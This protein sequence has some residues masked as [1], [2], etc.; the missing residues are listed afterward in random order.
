MTLPN[1]APASEPASAE[2][3]DRPRPTFDSLPLSQ[4]LRETLAEIGYLEPTPVQLAVFEPATRGRDLVVQAQTGTGKTASF[5]LPIV[6]SIVR[7]SQAEVQV[8]VLCPTRELALQVAREIERLASRKTIAV[9]SVYG[10]APMQRQIDAIAGGAQVV[11][12]TPGRVLDH[13]RRG[14]LEAEHVRLLV[15]D[16]S[17]EML[18]MGFER[19]L[20]AILEFLPKGRQTLLFSAT[21]P[22]EIE[23]IAKNKLRSPEFLTLSSDRV[24]AMG[25]QHF[26]Y[27]VSSDKVGSLARIIEVENPESAVVFCNTKEETQTV[28]Q[29]LVRQGFDADWLNGDLPQSEREKVMTATR[30]GRL[31]FLVAT[32]VAARG[33]DI[34]HLTHVINHDFPVTAEA[35]VHRTG[36]TGRAGRTGTAI[37]LVTPHDFGALYYLRLTYKIRPV[38]RELPSEGEIRTRSEADLVAMLVE[39]FGADGAFTA[40]DRSIARR[41]LTHDDAEQVVAGMI[42]NY[43]GARPTA[44]EEASAERRASRRDREV[45]HAHVAEP[46]RAEAEGD[47]APGGASAP[48]TERASETRADDRGERPRDRG[49]ERRRDGRDDRRGGRRDDRPRDDRPRDDR[50]RE[51]GSRDGGHR[52]ARFEARGDG[53]GRPD[54][55]D[56]QRGGERGRADERPAASREPVR[57]D[58]G[59]V[60]A[61]SP[62]ARSEGG[63]RVLLDWHPPVEEGDD[64]PILTKDAPALSAPHEPSR[65]VE[66]AGPVEQ[67]TD[68]L[69]PDTFVEL[70]LN[71][72]RRD[73]IRAGDIARQLEG[74]GIPAHLVRRIRVRDRHAFVSVDR[75]EQARAIDLLAASGLGGRS[76]VA[77]VAR[78]QRSTGG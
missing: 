50:P 40:D 12:G 73:G 37:S 43:L 66:G 49:R 7:R 20:S 39:A 19:E 30:E 18:S 60:D 31:R 72:G 5:G 36:R 51:A 71:V 9:T 29:A 13:L 62:Q 38:N 23:R 54:G 64:Q 77:E 15:L 57:H 25:I 74:G 28:A 2:P 52:E 21:V 78:E 27:T 32:D 59:M 75:D 22:P 41:L 76:V 8:L 10:G 69:L 1:L 70:F 33:I 65:A 56:A 4:E 48:L 35:Y 58:L 24:G 68:E 3:G 46:A 67:S 42:R 47:L 11:V 53:A 34:S 61:S 44:R 45:E 6:D 14:T 55:R 16:E 26:V 63:P 17:D